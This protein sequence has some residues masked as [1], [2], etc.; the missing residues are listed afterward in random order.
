MVFLAIAESAEISSNS[1]LSL[2]N[3]SFALVQLAWASLILYGNKSPFSLR[4]SSPVSGFFAKLAG[5]KPFKA[6]EPSPKISFAKFLY[7]S[8]VKKLFEHVRCR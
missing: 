8:L 7:Q 6:V 5:T 4:K 3:S 1:I 2:P